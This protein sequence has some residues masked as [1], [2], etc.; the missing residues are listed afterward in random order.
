MTTDLI[1]WKK[2][3]QNRALV[4]PWTLV[5]FSVG[6]AVGLMGIGM[7]EALVGA[8]LYE[9]AEHPFSRAG[10][11]KTLFNVSKPESFGNAV[12]DVGVF[13]VGVR[14]GHRWNAT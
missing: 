10:F 2:S 6:L 9:V 11:G 12:V 3:Q 14:A 5:H 1:A 8:V 7:T 13:A 4:D